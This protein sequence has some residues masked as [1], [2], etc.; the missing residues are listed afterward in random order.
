[1]AA[2]I[3][4]IADYDAIIQRI[5]K[6][7]V[8]SPRKWG[9]MSTPEMIRHCSLQLQL[10]LNQIP[11]PGY[12]GNALLRTTIGRYIGLYVAPW[13]IGVSA[14]RVMNIKENHINVATLESEKN[15]LLQL[16]NEVQQTNAFEPHPLLG[17]LNKK[18]WGRL[19]WKHLNHHLTQFSS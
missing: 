18:H 8:N 1:M 6:V 2:N 19:I 17:R 9:T 10:G 7:H 15:Q 13:R 3:F 14:P 4:T 12:E 5:H 16:L 11:F